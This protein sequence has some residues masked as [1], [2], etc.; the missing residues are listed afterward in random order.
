MSHPVSPVFVSKVNG[1][2]VRFF[3]NPTGE[4]GLPWHAVEDLY[5]ATYMPRSL[6][7]KMQAAMRRYC[8]TVS[9]ATD[10]IT[11]APHSMAQGLILAA[12]EQGF[13]P[14]ETHD[15]YCVA[16][17][18]AMTAQHNCLPENERLSFAIQSARNAFGSDGGRDE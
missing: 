12:Q 13:C 9:T 18:K 17:A 3:D 16:A 5:H 8:M 2:S 4:P 6:R 11:I 1:R 10:P 14:P 7:R 15:S